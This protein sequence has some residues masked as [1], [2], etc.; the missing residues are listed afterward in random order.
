MKSIGLLAALLLLASSAPATADDDAGQA[1][2]SARVAQVYY[3]EFVTEDV[4]S[5]CAAYA[6]TGLEFGEPDALFGNARTAVLPNG[7]MVG[8]RAPMRADEAPV[9]RPYWLV[10]DIEGALAAAVAKG[11]EVA[12]PPL[13]IPGRGT[14]AI[15]FLGGNQHG[16][17][18]LPR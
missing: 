15:Y 7:G 13:E 12:H 17:W 18:Q 6:A 16:L 5:I 3:L 11:A 9:V 10:E 4:E 2:A 14:F 1:K 8:V